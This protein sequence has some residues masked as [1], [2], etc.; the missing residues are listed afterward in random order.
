[1]IA[2]GW[3][4]KEIEARHIEV[5]NEVTDQLNQHLNATHTYTIVGVK[6]QVVAGK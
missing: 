6:Q 3:G 1:M 2:G 5:V 4:E